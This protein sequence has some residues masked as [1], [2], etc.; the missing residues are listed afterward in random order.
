M[1][2]LLTRQQ[3]SLWGVPLSGWLLVCRATGH[4]SDVREN[5]VY[6]RK[7]NGG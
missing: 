5:L 2:S 4:Q 6:D 7:L 1:Q 3:A